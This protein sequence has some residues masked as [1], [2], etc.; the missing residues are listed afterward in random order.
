MYRADGRGWIF[1]AN[2]RKMELVEFDL[3]ANLPRIKTDYYFRLSYMSLNL[4]QVSKKSFFLNFLEEDA[5]FN[6]TQKVRSVTLLNIKAWQPVFSNQIRKPQTRS[7]RLSM[8]LIF[9]T[10]QCDSHNGG[11]RGKRK[12]LPF[13]HLVTGLYW[14]YESDVDTQSVTMTFLTGGNLIDLD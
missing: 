8:H 6:F 1:Y 13:P 4:R 9:I 10:A 2:R 12:I 11:T 14:F 5:L 3:D 7:S